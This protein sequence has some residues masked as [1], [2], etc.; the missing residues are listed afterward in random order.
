MSR[1]FHEYTADPAAEA[2][3]VV[4]RCL[5]LDDEERADVFGT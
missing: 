5:I 1:T 2:G 3:G 4:R